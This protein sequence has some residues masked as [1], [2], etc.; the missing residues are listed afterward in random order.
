MIR[1]SSVYFVLIGRCYIYPAR[2]DI[3]KI[4]ERLGGP[5]DNAEEDNKKP[6]PE[7]DRTEVNE[8]RNLLKQMRE[9]TKE[10][11][12]DLTKQE[13]EFVKSGDKLAAQT[14]RKNCMTAAS[15]LKKITGM[16]LMLGEAQRKLE[17]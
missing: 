4:M 17:G 6:C 7:E 5:S 16:D 1:T 13:R 3:Q 14:T 2:G 10:T 11:I 15:N 12:D 9:K 8:F